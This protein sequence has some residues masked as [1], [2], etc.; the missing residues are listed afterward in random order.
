MDS[1]RNT[2]LAIAR[3]ENEY[4]ADNTEKLIAYMDAILERNKHINLTAVRD[5]DEAIHKHIVDSLSCT[6]L[7]EYQNARRVVD[8][9]TG[10]GFPGVPLAIASADKSFTLVDALNKRLKVI[11][12]LTSNLGITNITTLHSRAED[13]GNSKEHREKY[14]LCVSRAVASLDVL[15]E[16]CLPLVKVGGYMIAYKGE[17]VSRETEDARKAIEQLGGKVER[18]DNIEAS[19]ED[20][21]G[22]VLVV[23][24]KVKHTPSKYP[25]QSGQAKKH[26]IR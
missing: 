24:K 6:M 15:V 14:D 25:R 20:I 16:W 17:N 10:G 7:K 26:P 12:E 11:D 22:H 1:I 13:M 23:I 3:L 19:S 5:R 9:G 8:M 2:E 18:L 21:S 4:G